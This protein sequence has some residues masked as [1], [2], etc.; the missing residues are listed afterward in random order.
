MKCSKCNEREASFHYMSNING[1]CTELHLCSECAR[2]EGFAA[3]LDRSPID[4]FSEMNA[5]MNE[6]F[7]DFF[8]PHPFFPAPFA[9]FD[10]VY[11]GIMSPTGTRRRTLQ[12]QSAPQQTHNIPADAG[13]DVRRRRETEALRQQLD[14]AVREENYERAIELRDEI[15]RL[16][17]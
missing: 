1:E 8:S 9:E 10:R 12:Q 2:E 11:R 15:R 14:A 13:E 17:A 3:E 6:M 5:A 7:S 4:M 16:G